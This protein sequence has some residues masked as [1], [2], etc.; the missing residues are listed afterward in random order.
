MA[1]SPAAGCRAMRRARSSRHP[2]GAVPA[3]LLP[4]GARAQP[5]CSAGSSWRL[6]RRVCRRPV[7]TRLRRRR[8]L[9]PLAGPSDSTGVGGLCQAALRRTAAVLKYLARYTHRVAI[10]N[11]RLR[12]LRRHRRDLPV[13]GLRAEG[14]DR[15]KVMTLATVEFIRRFVHHVLPKGFYRFAITACSPTAPAPTTSLKPAACWTCRR[16]S[17]RPAI[18]V[19]PRPTNSSRPRTRVHAAAAA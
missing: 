11:R 18:P 5:A 7:L 4:A 3:R 13:D 17:P 16:H 9:R 8:G 15:Q 12:R 6:L 19:A 10:G 1:S 14:R 2:L